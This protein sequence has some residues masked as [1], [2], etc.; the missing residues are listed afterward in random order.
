LESASDTW[1]SIPSGIF[2]PDSKYRL[3]ASVEI[4]KPGGTGIPIAVISARFAPLPP[5]RSFI[6]AEPSAWPLAKK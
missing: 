3:H 1:E 2:R 5:K 6:L 4:V